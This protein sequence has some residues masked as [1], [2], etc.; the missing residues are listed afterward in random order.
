MPSSRTKRGKKAALL[1]AAGAALHFTPKIA[2][3]IFFVQAWES[4]REGPLLSGVFF[5]GWLAVLAW[6][7]RTGESG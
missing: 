5:L 7:M 1:A 6:E 4:H 2:H 3:D